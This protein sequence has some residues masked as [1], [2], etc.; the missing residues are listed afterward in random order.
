DVELLDIPTG[1]AG[2]DVECLGVTAL[3]VIWKTGRVLIGCHGV[4][5]PVVASTVSRPAWFLFGSD[6]T[7]KW[8]KSPPT[9]RV[10]PSRDR[11]RSWT[12]ACA[13]AVGLSIRR[14]PWP[15]NMPP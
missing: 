9:I 5:W 4:I 1:A 8:R 11:A 2:G 7:P 13:G 15:W 3:S 12:L 10:E 6:C 14:P